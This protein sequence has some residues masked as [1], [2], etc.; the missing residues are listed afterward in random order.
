MSTV[1]EQADAAGK[2]AK[3]DAFT[4]WYTVLTGAYFLLWWLSSD[5]DRIFN[6]YILLVPILALPGLVLVA[7]LVIGLG[8]NAFKR[9]WR[10]VISILAAPIIAASFFS[11]LGWLGVT[12]ERIRLEWWKSNYLAE[13][14]ALPAPADGARLKTWN[15]GETGGVAVANFFWT[16]VYDESDQIALPPSAWS[17]D[18]RQK[19]DRVA[20]VPKS[21][22]FY[23]VLHNA[24]ND[25]DYYR[26]FTVRHLG[27][28]F[29]VVEELIQ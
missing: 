5:L 8:V 11:L 25:D 2:A 6:L 10:R 27:G 14:A 13:V 4:P 12:T 29:Y 23:S 1:P 9:R 3:S 19:A 28:H 18:W 21:G 7:T 20:L 26:R 15:W 16:L 17:S 24:Q 22:G